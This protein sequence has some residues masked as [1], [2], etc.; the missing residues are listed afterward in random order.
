MRIGEVADSVGIDP[1]T[2]RF[3]EAEGVIPPPARD[4]NGYRDYHPTDVERLRF[5]VSARSIGL[6]LDD[7][8]EMLGLRDRGE[9]PCAYVRD[10]L[11]RQADE[12]GRRIE[13]LE[14]MAAELRRLRELA[15]TLPDTAGDD[16]CICH[17]LT[18]DGHR[19]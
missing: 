2:I 3:Y 16:P 17:I 13:D 6:P 9:P 10:V 11:D 5:V 14:R 12:I 8:R 15:S 7:I 4:P 19:N 18:G 1:P